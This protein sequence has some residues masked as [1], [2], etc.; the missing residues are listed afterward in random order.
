[1]DLLNGGPGSRCDDDPRFAYRTQWN[2]AREQHF[3]TYRERHCD[4]R[5]VWAQADRLNSERVELRGDSR[6]LDIALD[7]GPRGGSV[8]RQRPAAEHAWITIDR[9][10]VQRLDRC[11]RST[12]GRA[13]KGSSVEEQARYV[14][15]DSDQ[16]DEYRCETDEQNQCLA[17]ILT[18]PHLPQSK[19]PLASCPRFRS[20]RCLVQRRGT[21]S[22]VNRHRRQPDG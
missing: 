4:R 7:R 6:I 1:M 22:V 11:G 5:T 13:D 14:R 10:F 8:E 12:V 20:D 3:H 2:D 15:H 17:A 19:R 9:R 18:R 21:P 16:R